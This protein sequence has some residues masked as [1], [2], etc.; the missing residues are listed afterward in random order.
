LV[1]NFG[2]VWHFRMDYAQHDS[3]RYAELISLPVRTIR[4]LPKKLT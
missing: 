4:G 2:P 1:N 3:L